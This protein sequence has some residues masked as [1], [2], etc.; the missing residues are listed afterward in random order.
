MHRF[1]RKNLLLGGIA[2]LIV[3]VIAIATRSTL[4]TAG[5]DPGKAIQ[6]RNEKLKEAFRLAEGK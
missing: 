5:A 4:Q 1:N 3:I 2:A 6:D